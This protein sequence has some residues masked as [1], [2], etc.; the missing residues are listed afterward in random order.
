MATCTPDRYS[1]LSGV[2]RIHLVLHRVVLYR[3]S[4][5][6]LDRQRRN[7]GEIVF[8]Q[9]H[10]AAKD[11]DHVLR[12]EFLGLGVR[13]V[14]LKAKRVHSLRPQEL[15]VVPTVRLVA[16]RTTLL[17]CRLVEMGFLV[18]FSLISVAAQANVDCVGLRKSWRLSSMRIMTVGAVSLRA[19]MLNFG[20]FNLLCLLIVASK[21]E[22]FRVLLNEDHLTVLCWLVT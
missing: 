4:T 15:C 5:T 10:F 17:K 20:A 6:V 13:T 3:V 19:G 14:T 7:L 21:A 1:H 2:V 22:R 8:G 9:F 16:C 11:G 12:F 18:L